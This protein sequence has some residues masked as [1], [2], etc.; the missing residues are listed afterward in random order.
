MPKIA[1][2]GSHSTGKSTIIDTL[3]QNAALTDRFTFK[4][5]IL[6]DIKKSGISI[7]EY[8]T[9]DTQRLVMAKFLEYSTIPN[10]IL[11]RCALDGLVY[12]AYLY[13]QKQVSKS[14]LRIAEAI[15]E[16]VKYDIYFYISPEFDIVP[17]GTRSENAGFRTRVAELFEE[18]L[19][20]YNIEPIRLTGSVEDR[21]MQ[22]NNTIKAY[23]SWISQENKEAKEASRSLI[24]Q[25]FKGIKLP[26]GI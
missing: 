6:R 2:S 11:D 1:I 25:C 24:S 8:G 13:E 15:F 10:S 20:A 5:E 21:V 19:T 23:D 3:K 22:F 14:T 16:N 18:Y 7:N 26:E 12:T 9:D 4:G 17:D